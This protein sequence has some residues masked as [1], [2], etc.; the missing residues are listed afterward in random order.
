MTGKTTKKGRNDRQEQYTKLILRTVLSPAWSAL[1][2]VA[3]AIY[4]FLKFE[5]RGSRNNNNGKISLSY[6]QAAERLGV[7]KNTA[8]KGFHE[9]QAKGFIVVTSFGALGVE[10]EARGPT[11]EITELAMPGAHV[12]RNLF[13][14]WRAGQ[15]LDVQKHTTN[16]P[17]G[18]NR[19][20]TP[21]QNPR[22]SCLKN[23][24]VQPIPVSKIETPCPNSSDVQA[25]NEVSTVSD[26]GTSLITIPKRHAVPPDLRWPTGPFLCTLRAGT[27]SSVLRH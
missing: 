20:K 19:R 12:G 7:N 9:L 23:R 18:R 25:I 14:K 24:D 27:S 4:P 6:R 26:I 17:A 10:G 2:T 5:W 13:L 15:D 21:S 3:Q 8:Q 16:N 1:P 11:Y 22:R